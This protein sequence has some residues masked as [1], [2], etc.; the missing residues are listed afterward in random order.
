MNILNLARPTRLKG[1]LVAIFVSG[2]GAYS[3]SLHANG[4]ATETKKQSPASKE[5]VQQAQALS[6][7][8]R[9]VSKSV[10]PSVVN[11]RST[12]KF[13]RTARSSKD[14]GQVQP[15]PFNPF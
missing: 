9:Q 4:Q 7:A 3:L 14:N 6:N 8:F 10:S 12:Q 1:L 15:E 5:E 2:A 13:A 11:I